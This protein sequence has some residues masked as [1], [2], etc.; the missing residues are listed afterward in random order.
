M[1]TSNPRDPRSSSPGLVEKG[2]PGR[3]SGRLGRAYSPNV[4][5]HKGDTRMS[6]TR[7]R[8]TYGAS[9]PTDKEGRVRRVD[10][11][12]EQRERLERRRGCRQAKMADDATP[13]MS[14]T[15]FFDAKPSQPPSFRP[16]SHPPN[17][18]HPPSPSLPLSRPFLVSSSCFFFHDLSPATNPP[19]TIFTRTMM[20]SLAAIFPGF[21]PP[22]AVIN[23]T[24]PCHQKRKR[25]ERGREREKGKRIQRE[26]E[27]GEQ[28]SLAEAI[29]GEGVIPLSVFVNFVSCISRHYSPHQTF[30]RTLCVRSLLVRAHRVRCVSTEWKE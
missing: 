2:G 30:P 12:G 25:L 7:G 13:T 28:H 3:L 21:L 11:M 16:E 9:C 24:I 6:W 22:L 29:A 18:A 8:R 17:V 14:I 1:A 23:A 5:R 20:R 4:T 27:E 10:G 19:S 26:R 15:P